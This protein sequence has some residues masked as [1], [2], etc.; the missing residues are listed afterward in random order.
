MAKVEQP[1]FVLPKKRNGKKTNG[2][3]G[4]VDHIITVQVI[5]ILF[6]VFIELTF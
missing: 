2:N 6:V 1:L 4:H 5:V 3:A